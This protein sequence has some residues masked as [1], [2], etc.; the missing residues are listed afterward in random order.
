MFDGFSKRGIL[1]A[2]GTLMVIIVFGSFGGVYLAKYLAGN[3]SYDPLA[4]AGGL[5]PAQVIEAK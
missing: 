1:Y 2:V 4:R 3:R 5:K